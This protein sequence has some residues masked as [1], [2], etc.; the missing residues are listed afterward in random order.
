MRCRKAWE[1]AYVDRIKPKDSASALRLGDLVHQALAGF[2]L[3][4]KSR[5]RK[6]KPVRGPHPAETFNALYDALDEDG[7]GFAAKSGVD[8]DDEKWGDARVL[9]TEMLENY[10]AQYGQDE[11]YRIISPE[12]PFQVPIRDVNR[13]T[14]TIY[15]G[16]VDALAQDLETGLLVFLEHKT[17]AAIVVS[18]LGMD[19]QAGSY[20]TFGP[21]YLRQKGYLTKGQKLD[22]ILYNFLRKGFKDTRP[23][24]ELG[25]YLNKRTKAQEKAGLPAE[26]SKTQPPPLF[27]RQMVYRSDADRMALLGRVREQ[28]V[29]MDMVRKGLLPA[30]KSII[31]GCTGMFG[32]SFRDMCELHETGGD[33]EYFK[34]TM[35]TEW[36]PYMI[37][38][39]G[40]GETD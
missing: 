20:W 7:K 32:C 14:L 39:Q 9:G 38:E 24:N 33:W 4:E 18:H 21:E 16:T 30:T 5:G 8:T 26:V 12:M 22:G 15:V 6:G 28:A 37:H 35:M 13:R 34:K 31:Q 2:Y 17:A 25:Q 23:Q 27:R 40:K 10:I 3:A 11:R 29:E 19:E 36:D 1:W